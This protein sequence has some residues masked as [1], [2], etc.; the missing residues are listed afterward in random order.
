[1]TSAA[2]TPI[3][4]KRKTTILWMRCCDVLGNVVYPD[5]D[6]PVRTT[7]DPREVFIYL[8]L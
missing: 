1:M 6:A 5:P 3:V 4:S 8:L 7:K 2:G